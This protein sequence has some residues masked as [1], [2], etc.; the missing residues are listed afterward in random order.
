ML[1]RIGALFTSVLSCGGLEWAL[2]SW[3]AHVSPDPGEIRS[4][5]GFMLQARRDDSTAPRVSGSPGSN[6]LEI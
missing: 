2:P 6:L 5:G 4:V 3:V 1:S